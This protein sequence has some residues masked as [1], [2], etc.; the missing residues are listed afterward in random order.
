MWWRT[1]RQILLHIALTEVGY[2]LPSVGWRAGL[3]PETLKSAS[4]QQALEL[5]RRETR[6]FLDELTMPGS[7]RARIIVDDETWSVRKVLRRLV[8]HERLHYKGILRIAREYNRL[9]R[10]D[11]AV[12]DED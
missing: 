10:G 8:W 9:H 11:A 4:W 5:S 1:I 7:D 12:R 2:Y 3:N 6:R